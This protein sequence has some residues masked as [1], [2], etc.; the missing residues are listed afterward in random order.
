MQS[1]VSKL[2]QIQPALLIGM[3][4]ALMLTGCSGSTTNKTATP[5]ILPAAGTY[6]YIPTL[7]ISDATPG[8]SIYYTTNGSTPT[9]SS[10]LYS[11]STPLTVPQSETVNVIAIAGS[12]TSAVASA[13][14]T[15]NLPPAPTPV[16][17][18][19]PGPYIGVQSVTATDTAIG[20][21]MYYTTNGT[22][23]TSS[24]TPYTGPI[25][26][27][28]SET[29]QVVAISQSYG[30]GYSAVGG[31]VYAILVSPTFSV[32]SGTYPTAQTLTLSVPTPGASIYY[33]TNGSAPTT[34]ST[35][36]TGPITVAS[37]EIVSA[38]AAVGTL[39]SAPVV[40]TYL[41]Q[42][43][44]VTVVSGSAIGGKPVVGAT[45]QLY[46]VG[47]A[48]YGSAA[49]PLISSAPVT[50]ST[51]SVTLAGSY[52]CTHGTYL[53]LTASGGTTAT[54]QS[55]NPNLTLAAA[56]G[57]C[58]TLTANSSFLLNEQTTVAAAYALAHFASGTTFGTTQV[59]KPGSGSSAPADNFATSSTN[60]VGIANAM[61]VAQILASNTTGATGNNASNTATPEWWQVNLISDMLAACNQ[62]VG[63]SSTPCTTLFGNVGGTTPGDTLQAALDLALTP[64]LSSIHI[65]S[66][67]GLVSS[68]SPF[69]PYPPSASSVYDFSIAISY[70]PAAASGAKLLTQPQAV[71]IDSLGNAWVGSQSSA[72]PYLASLVELTPTGIGI[73]AG[74]TPGNYAISAYALSSTPT[75]STVIGGQYI[76]STST[77]VTYTAD[78]LFA[79]SIDTNNNVWITDRQKS[80]MAIL[81]GSGTTYSSSYSYQ[82]GG[83]ALDSGGKGAVGYALNA[84]SYPTSVYLDG[85]NNVWFMMEGATQN[86]GCAALGTSLTS[87]S[88]V[89]NAGLAAFLGE[90]PSNVAIG[91]DGNTIG[92]KNAAYL[93]IDPG[94]NDTVTISGSSQPISG[95]PFVWF[96]GVNTGVN[97]LVPNF[98]QAVGTAAPN[99]GVPY[100]SC[101]TSAG[102]IGSADD[103]AAAET[104]WTDTSAVPAG[105]GGATNGTSAHSQ[106][107]IYDIPNPNLTGDFL[108]DI[109]MVEDMT[110]DN[111]GNLWVANGDVSTFS[112]AATSINTIGTAYSAYPSPPP[113]IPAD[114]I[115]AAI[116]KIKPNWGAGS[117]G[118]SGT[119]TIY[120]PTSS[121]P[122]NFTY[123][124]FHNQSGLFDGSTVTNVPEYITTDGGGNAYFTMS[125]DNYVNAIT[126]SGTALTQASGTATSP[127]TGFM[128][129]ICTNCTNNGT[130][131]TYQRA[132]S[133]TLSRPTIDQAGNIWVPLQGSGSNSLYLLVGA[134]VPRVQPDS[135]GLKNGTFASKP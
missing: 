19:V 6:A 23:P 44:G 101:E 32:S 31:G 99:G 105:P 85:S 116:S 90:N 133:Y 2:V 89:Y 16:L 64:T 93:T 113:A 29:L 12:N 80:N 73:Q 7:T 9:A 27:T 79:P 74:A 122:Y 83:N 66:L 119:A 120:T 40:N 110:W 75:V 67:Y 39:T 10:T 132:N 102:G 135:L 4:I 28:N 43:P 65:G 20:A 96:A 60:I 22:T 37:S 94:K 24:S 14:Y 62:S 76:P 36:Y 108:H 84:S 88:S 71:A 70:T 87:Y 124:V 111:A 112:N 130:T 131:A 100:P 125:T 109:G 115:N 123:S 86:G 50:N 52:T 13:S 78:G 53:Y 68:S 41:I 129:S 106:S 47:A 55:V 11:P 49:T 56:V 118:T 46:E 72:T 25:S 51:G 17:S 95:S 1:R 107:W 34:S 3:V 92:N 15:I 98:T 54:G 5:V 42:L 121:G 30:Y 128:G 38:I 114:Q 126:N 91:K 33:T 57:L 61:A 58:D 35:L 103:T 81:T 8:A 104:Y 18:P 59:S 82:N 21:T 97:L 63:S 127:T 77:P 45:V 48:G 26:V 134:A 69:L 117:Q